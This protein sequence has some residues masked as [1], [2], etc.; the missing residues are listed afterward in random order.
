MKKKLDHSAMYQKLALILPDRMT[1]Y[2]SI[3]PQSRG[4]DQWIIPPTYPLPLS[5]SEVQP[6]FFCLA[7]PSASAQAVF[8]TS[9]FFAVFVY[10]LFHG[11]LWGWNPFFATM[12][13]KLDHSAMYQKLALIL[14]DRMTLYFSNTPYGT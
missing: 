8:R 2:F 10:F 11:I 14:P 6:F 7:V 1:L 4:S 13:K 12:K 5:D 3:P 9:G